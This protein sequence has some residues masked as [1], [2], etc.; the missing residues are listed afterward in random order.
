M[1]VKPSFQPIFIFYSFETHKAITM[2][3]FVPLLRYEYLPNL[4]PGLE[5]LPEV[6]FT[7]LI[8]EMGK[9]EGGDIRPVPPRC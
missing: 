9:V 1:V 2:T 3:L 6:S 8:R 5:Y 4:S 7:D